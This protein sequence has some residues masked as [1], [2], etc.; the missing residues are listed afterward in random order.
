LHRA[1]AFHLENGGRKNDRQRKPE[2]KKRNKERGREA[3]RK[4]E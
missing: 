1:S 4:N 2:E 3:L